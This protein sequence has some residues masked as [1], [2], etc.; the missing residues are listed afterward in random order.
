MTCY[1]VAVVGLGVYG[2]SLCHAASACG[3]SV[4]GFDAGG[5]RRRTNSSSGETRLM[6][7]TV[8]E[9]P[10]YLGLVR[11]SREL[12]LEIEQSSPKPLTENTGFLLIAQPGSMQQRHHSTRSVVTSASAMARA[13]GIAHE[14]CSGAEIRE[15][16][17]R[18]LI[19]PTSHTFFEP[20]AV[21]LYVDRINDALLDHATSNGAIINF[22]RITN[23]APDGGWLAVTHE[24]GQ[25]RARHVA[26]CTGAEGVRLDFP[27]GLNDARVQRQPVKWYT[28]NSYLDY[29]VVVC[30]RPNKP[31][32]YAFPGIRGLRGAKFSQENTDWIGSLH[33]QTRKPWAEHLMAT[34]DRESSSI[35]SELGAP[36]H[37]AWC[38]YVAVP[39]AR[40]KVR[41]ARD[42]P[43]TVTVS[44]CSGHGY[45]YAPAV[46]ERI[47]GAIVRR[48]IP[49][50]LME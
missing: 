5:L 12:I 9:D 32:I 39:G 14:Y 21:T 31:L 38:D 26:V 2:L 30:T 23:V 50:A 34:M 33:H 13:T 24:S 19:D 17:P 15:R 10:A 46:A 35:V 44:C 16:F 20:G 47:T 41:L 27:T 28:E 4:I 7:E 6:R 25:I 3:L 11:R 42:L 29:P 40:L 43:R 8:I 45:K 36:C 48:R 49:E 22:E 1:D 37:E 18:L